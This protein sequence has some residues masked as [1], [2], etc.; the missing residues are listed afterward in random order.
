MRP[1]MTCSF[2]LATSV[3]TTRSATSCP[4]QRTAV[5]LRCASPGGGK[6]SS[7]R[8]ELGCCVRIESQMRK[9]KGSIWVWRWRDGVSVGEGARATRRETASEAHLVQLVPVGKDDR[10]IADV[11]E[12]L[13]AHLPPL[14][15]LERPR[16]L[17]AVGRERRPEGRTAGDD[18]GVLVLAPGLLVVRDKVRV[19]QVHDC[20]RVRAELGRQLSR[21]ERD[22]KEDNDTRFSV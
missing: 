3:K 21:C 20:G 9:M 15:L 7:H 8:I 1:R 5:S 13:L 17:G 12:H 19:R 10:V 14:V 16:R 22:G 6:R 4:A 11:R 18:A 2:L